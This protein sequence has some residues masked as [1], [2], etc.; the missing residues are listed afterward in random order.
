MDGKILYVDNAVEWGPKLSLIYGES[1]IIIQR[2]QVGA[3]QTWK[4]KKLE[5]SVLVTETVD[6]KAQADS[7][8][9]LVK[10]AQY[11]KIPVIAFSN[12]PYEETKEKATEL[13]MHA[14]VCKH[15]AYIPILVEYIKTLLDDKYV[16]DGNLLTHELVK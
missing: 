16:W 3:L 12:S 7:L 11:K 9:R 1:R 10:Y 2:T 6:Y 14:A 5:I 8:E 15:Y 4:K 13:K